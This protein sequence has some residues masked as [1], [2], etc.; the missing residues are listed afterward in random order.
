MVLDLRNLST[1]TDFFVVATA[2]S[3]PQLL[4][5]T[6]HIEQLLKRR[7]ERAG[8][9]EGR[10]T[11]GST[12]EIESPESLSWVLLDCGDVVVHVFNPP[13][14]A[15][16]QLERLWADAPRLAINFASQH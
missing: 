6:E 4:A 9:I 3:R 15:F 8:H 13:A 12:R 11:R 7:K 5:V 1:L 10:L 2:A 14:R 16:Y